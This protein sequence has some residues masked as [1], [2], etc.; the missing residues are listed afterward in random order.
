MTKILKPN[1]AFYLTLINTKFSYYSSLFFIILDEVR[2]STL[3]FRKANFSLN[4]STSS[5]TY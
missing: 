2:T 5:N 1:T 3:Y 4:I